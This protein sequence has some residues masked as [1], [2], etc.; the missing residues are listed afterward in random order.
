[1][2]LRAHTINSL[3]VKAA[4]TRGDPLTTAQTWE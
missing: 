2:F 1:M 3:A 4:V